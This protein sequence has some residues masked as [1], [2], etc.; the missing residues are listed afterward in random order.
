MARYKLFID[1]ELYVNEN[2]DLQTILSQTEFRDAVM[3][4][5]ISPPTAKNHRNVRVWGIAQTIPGL[6]YICLDSQ[7]DVVLTMERSQIITLQIVILQQIE[8]F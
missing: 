2:K 3:T 1:G 7:G 4:P 6:G 8:M 5:E